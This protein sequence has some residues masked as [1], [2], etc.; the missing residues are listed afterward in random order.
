MAEAVALAGSL[1]FVALALVVP[2]GVTS[3]V[4]AAVLRALRRHDAPDLPIGGQVLADVARDL[5]SLGG[6]SVLVLVVLLVAGYLVADGRVRDGAAVAGAAVG[7]L[8]L[9]VLLKLAFA[10]E[11]PSVVPHLMIAGSGSFPS[12]HSMLAAVIYPTMGA[13]LARFAKK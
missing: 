9:D 12:G 6:T 2:T 1:S 5:T 8:L 10:R 3:G 11:R 13:L 4:D 7:G